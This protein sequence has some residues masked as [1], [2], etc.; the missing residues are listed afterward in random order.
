MKTMAFKN[1]LTIP[2]KVTLGS[3]N[4]SHYSPGQALKVLGG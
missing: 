1:V 3:K 2:V 4:Q